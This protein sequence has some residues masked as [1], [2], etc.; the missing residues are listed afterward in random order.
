MKII[1]YERGERGLILETTKGRIQIEI[2]SPS[3][4]HIVY[5]HEEEFST[6]ES[7]AVVPEAY[8]GAEWSLTESE[9][10]IELITSRLQLSILKATGAFRYRDRNGRLLAKEPDRGGKSLVAT[11]AV[12]YVYDDTSSVTSSMSA[13]GVRVQAEA[14]DAIVRKAYHTKLEFEW[15]EGEALY[16][17]GSHEE[18]IMNLRGTSQ[19]LYQQN[20][21]AVVPMLVSTKG[22]GILM[23]SYGLMTFH[24]DAHG[25]YLWTDTDDELDYYFIYGPEMGEVVSGFRTLTGRAP[26]LP[27]WAFGYAQSKERYKSQEELINVVKEYRE[28]QIPLDMIILD[29][30]SWTGNLW[31][32]KS[33]DPERFPDPAGM[34][35]ILHSMD[36]KLMVSIWPIMN[37]D[38]PNHREM[39]EHNTLLGNQATYD[40]FSEKARQLYWKQAYEGLFSHGIDAWWC[41]CTEPFEADWKG[42]VKPEPEQRLAINTGRSKKYLDPE[43]INA[44]SLMHSKGIYEGQREVTL[45]KRVVN[46]TRSA[47]SGQQRYSA[48]TWSG[49]TCAKW[50]TLRKQVP[51]GLNFC[52]AGVPYWTSDIGAFFVAKKEQWFWDGDYDRGCD[53]PAYRELYLRWFQYGAFLPMFRSHG[54]DTPR[55]VWRFG[56]PGSVIYDTL[57]TFIKLRYRLL[58]Y[59]YSIA[60]MVTLRHDTMM[61]P[62]AFDFRADENTYDISDQYMLGPALLV[63]PVLEPVGEAQRFCRSVYLPRGV[64]WYD[65]WSG[66]Q[67]A[68]G[69]WVNADA[70][71]DTMPLFVRAGSIVPVGPDIKHSLELQDAPWQ[72]LVYSGESGSFTIYEDEGDS[73]RYEQGQYAA[74]TIRWD[75]EASILT[76][77]DREGSYAGMNPKR[78]FLVH[79][80]TEGQGFVKL[81]ADPV[82]QPIIYEGKTVRIQL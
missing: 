11:E 5:T 30:M 71:L 13:D 42:E 35:R 9:G 41:D 77:E 16:G 68:G 72:L 10:T 17:L 26:M 81:T 61:R 24:D 73:Y 31:G 74:T 62:L 66:E 58:P 78:A 21:K 34:M 27:R 23:D 49:D 15:A 63:N 82:G 14:K 37:N 53:D 79:K 64:Q 76:I 48:I 32:Q 36:A 50:E 28:R 51:A 1:G 20:M 45:E 3:I 40:A 2:Y 44:Y 80:V 70:G 69:Q 7:L 22:Y 56:E 57:V 25:S 18:G 8:Q 75:D 19:Y 65:F 29:W 46:L 54:T 59:I 12:R 60:G 4:L 55:E 47:Y 52:A 38:G 43:Y 67:H 33:F 39:K 6:K